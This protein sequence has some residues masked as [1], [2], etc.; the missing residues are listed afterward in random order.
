MARSLSALLALFL[1]WILLSGM[2]TPF[3]LA[4]GAGSALAVLIF[5]HRMD[6]VDHEGHPIHLGWRALLSYWPWLLKEIVKS[7]WDVSRRILSP[8]LPISPT[9]VRFRPSQQT[10]MG[11]V[12]H[13]NS[14]TL[15]PGTIAV[16]VGTGRIPGA[17][18][19]ARRR[20]RL[21][22]S[23]MDRRCRRAGIPLMFAAAI[24]ALLVTVALALVR[25]ALGPHG[26]R[27]PA[28]R[29]HHRHLR[30]AAAGGAG[31]SRWP[32]GVS[33]PGAGLWPAQRDRHIAVLKFFRQGNLGDRGAPDHGERPP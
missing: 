33:R 32:A 6:V 13:A 27:P 17:C 3:L 5:A 11:L 9:L 22:G 18:A 7:A 12:I 14:I 29:Q 28:G 8:S 15:T 20:R 19:D 30:H 16:E 25:A 2:F 23:E 21:A 4:A 31:F 1:F 26:V 24:L 10:D